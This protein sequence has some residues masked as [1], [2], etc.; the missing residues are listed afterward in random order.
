MKENTNLVKGISHIDLK[1]IVSKIV[2]NK[3][4]YKCRERYD[5][6]VEIDNEKVRLKTACLFIHSN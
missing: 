5:Q 2:I 1:L 6:V 3:A 4:I